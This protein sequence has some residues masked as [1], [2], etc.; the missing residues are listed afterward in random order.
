MS[1][2]KYGHSTLSGLIDSDSDDVQFIAREAMPTPDSAA[3]NKPLGRKGRGKGKAAIAAKVTKTKAPARRTSGRLS[4][5]FQTSDRTKRSPKGAVTAG[6][7]KALADKTNQQYASDT[8]E[9]EE[10]EQN[11]DTAMGD[12]LDSTVVAM[13]ELKSKATKN[14]A[15]VGRGQTGKG[16]GG[17]TKSIDEISVPNAPGRPGATKKKAAA[18]QAV[19]L[20]SSPEKIILESQVLAMEVDDTAVEEAVEAIVSKTAHNSPYSRSHSRTRQPS[21]QRRRAASG[22]DTERNDPSLRRKLGDIT[23]KYDSLNVKYQDLREIG[24]KEAE[25]NFE[26]LRKQSEEKTAGESRGG[27]GD[28]ILLI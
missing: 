23:K 18:K 10:F 4:A 2:S 11:E 26:R 16:S 20:E 1:R 15:S 6:K 22:S 27:L 17:R 25:R 7:R 19:G 14:K 24:I 28:D 8:E 21:V 12:E 13:K 9:V 5:R 3:E